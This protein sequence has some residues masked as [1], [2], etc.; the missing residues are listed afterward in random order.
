MLLERAL[1]ADVHRETANGVQN[2]DL[3][4]RSWSRMTRGTGKTDSDWTRASRSRCSSS[5]PGELCQTGGFGG[6]PFTGAVTDRPAWTGDHSM[7]AI[8]ESRIPRR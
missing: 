8:I 3:Q 6:A 2:G 1:E 7:A 4:P 5:V